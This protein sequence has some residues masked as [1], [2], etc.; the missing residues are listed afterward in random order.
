MNNKD[1]S[2]DS[3]LIGCNN[4]IHPESQEV[5]KMLKRRFQNVVLLMMMLLLMSVFFNSDR[6]HALPELKGDIYV[7]DTVDILTDEDK[8][9]LAELGRKLEN[10]TTAQLSV[11]IIDNLDEQNINSY[12]NDVFNSFK[13]GENGVLFVYSIEDEQIKIEIGNSLKDRLTDSKVKEIL[14]EYARPYFK[15]GEDHKI[16]TKT[17]AA[18]YNEVGAEYG[19]DKSDMAKIPGE[20]KPLSLIK[21]L[22]IA[23]FPVLAIVDIVFFR[24]HFFFL[25]INTVTSLSSISKNDE[26]GG[27]PAKTGK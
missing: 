3:S 20:N 18:L 1:C 19:I 4:K 5:M 23:F 17:Y 26:G 24:G 6:V 13:L 8:A 22:M 2:L 7:Q 16:I 27:R 12:T 14:D 10:L 21:I 9:L 11:L 25:L 15:F